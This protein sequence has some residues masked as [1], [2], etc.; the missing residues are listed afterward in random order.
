[1][2]HSAAVGAVRKHLDRHADRPG[3]QG[4]GRRDSDAGDRVSREVHRRFLRRF[5]PRGA[6]VLEIGAGAD[7]YTTELAARGCRVVV[8]DPS[9]ARLAAHQRRVRAT[10]AERSVLR[11]EVLDPTDVSRYADGEFDVVLAYGGP[12]STVRGS[13]AGVLRGLLRIVAPDGIVVASVASLL[14]SWRHHPPGLD[15]R[16]ETGERRYRWSDVVALVDEAGGELVDGSA[17]NWAS[18]GDPGPLA[19]VA[20]DRDRW[21]RFLEHEVAACAEPGARDGGTYILFAARQR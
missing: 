1:M 7:R 16:A 4:W 8:T 17:S 20:A 6:R 21:R 12:L 18:A 15:G 9:S 14:G 11:R 19:H 3:E 10:P 13:A 5:V 2:D